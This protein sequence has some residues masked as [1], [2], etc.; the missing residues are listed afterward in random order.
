MSI[1]LHL[2]SNAFYVCCSCGDHVL[3]L[4][5]NAKFVLFADASKQW[6]FL[7]IGVSKN[8]ATSQWEWT[9]GSEMRYTNWY[10]ADTNGPVYECAYMRLPPLGVGTWHKMRCL[11]GSWATLCE[12]T[13]FDV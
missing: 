3:V 2:R 1:W 12:H 9:D 8:I 13:S 11:Q 10:D 5:T 4:V 7:A 6:A